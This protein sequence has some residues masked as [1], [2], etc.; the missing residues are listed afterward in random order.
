MYVSFLWGTQMDERFYRDRARII[1]EMAS[2]ADPF[3]KK[4]LLLLASNY[5][6]LTRAKMLD[7]TSGPGDSGRNTDEAVT[8]VSVAPEREL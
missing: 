1:R 7:V 4:R 3:I 5:D 8:R 6:R 2:E